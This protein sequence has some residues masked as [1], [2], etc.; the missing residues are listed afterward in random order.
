VADSPR[1]VFPAL[2]GLYRAL[3]PFTELL[4]RVVAGLSL[5]AHGYPKF[6]ALAQNAA[7]FEQAGFRPGMAWAIAVGLSETVGGLFLAA[8]FLTR[9]V[10]V[11]I[12]IFLLTAIVYHSQFGFYWNVR[13]FEYPLFW[14]IVVFHFLIRGGG[15]FSLDHRLGRE[16]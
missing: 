15:R 10:A 4:I 2:G 8:G 11:P 1:L 12:L 3:A 5:V 6:F 16:V 14:S 7:F 9:L 13:G